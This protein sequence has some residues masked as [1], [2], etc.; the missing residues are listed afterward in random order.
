VVKTAAQVS[1]CSPSRLQS[2]PVGFRVNTARTAGDNCQAV[3][4][5]LPCELFCQRQAIVRRASGADNGDAEFI[6]GN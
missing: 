3:C 4:G 1:E 5:Q 2:A 6:F